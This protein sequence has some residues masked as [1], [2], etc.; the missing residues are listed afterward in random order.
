MD[1][2][3]VVGM[4]KCPCYGDAEL[5]HLA[6]GKYCAAGKLFLQA[7]AGHKFHRVKELLIVLTKT[8]DLHDVRMIELSQCLDLRLETLTK[9]GLLG[10][11]AGQQLDRGCLVQGVVDAQVD[12][13]HSAAAEFADDSIGAKM[14]GEHGENPAVY[15]FYRNHVLQFLPAVTGFSHLLS[16]F[17]HPLPVSGL[18]NVDKPAGITS[19]DT[20]DMVQRLARPAKVGHAGTLDPLARGVLL[21]C[22]GS[23]TRLVEYVQRMPKRYAGTFLLGRTSATEDTDGAAT[24]LPNPPIPS[25]AEIEAAALKFIGK[26]QQRPPAFSALKVDGR[27]AYDLA[28]RGEAVELK[29]RPIEVHLLKVARY[30]YP[31]LDLEI[32]C[33]GGTYV[34]SLGRDLAESLGTAAVMSALT[35]TAVGPWTV[36]AAADPR[37][38]TTTNWQ[39]RLEPLCKAVAGL[40]VHELTTAE[41][42]RV[43]QGLFIPVATTAGT[44]EIAAWIVAATSWQYWFP[45]AMD[46][47][48][49]QRILSHHE[50]TPAERNA[51]T[52][53]APVPEGEGRLMPSPALSRRGR[54]GQNQPLEVVGR[55]LVLGDTRY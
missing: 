6:P 34:R 3:A 29:P 41:V 27:R 10:H 8:E 43:R 23:A 16:A 13:S 54:G 32:Q 20:V 33:S 14:R 48:A 45:A 55:R 52:P 2:T 50:G 51:L 7:A 36:D 5:G 49:R 1:Y 24:L 46:N 40:S 12:S 35:R 21:I 26:S 28:R 37:V 17:G 42:S 30:D 39:S 18:L 44:Q 38:L 9:I 47:G 31:E 25:V 15:F 4:A 19:R 22:V 11:V 53:A